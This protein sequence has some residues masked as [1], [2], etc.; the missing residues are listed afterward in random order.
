MYAVLPVAS[1][2]QLGPLRKEATAHHGNAPEDSDRGKEDPGADFSEDDGCEW[3]KKDV[4][5][6]E[7][8]GDLRV[9]IADEHKV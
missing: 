9:A 5:H 3:L 4:C 1:T 6:E 7:D 2:H 8:Q